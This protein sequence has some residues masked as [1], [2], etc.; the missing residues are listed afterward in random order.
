MCADTIT[1]HYH[2]VKPEISGSPTTWGVKLNADLD[3]IDAQL[4]TTTATANAASAAVSA[5][6]PNIVIGE[7]KLYAGG[8]L[9]LPANWLFC[10]GTVYNNTD[11]PLLAPVLNNAFGGV[12][13][14]SNAVP[15]LNLAF[16][17][18][19]DHVT[20]FIGQMGGEATHLL[21]AA[22]MPSHT[23]TP[24]VTDPGHVHGIPNVFQFGAVY[25]EGTGASNVFTYGGNTNSAPTGLTVANANTGGGVAHN[26][27]PPYVR[28]NFII[29]Y[30]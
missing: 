12:P 28:L 21:T 23:H 20:T 6:A 4:F 26:N 2:W 22:E 14:T 3:L 5:L 25:P 11:I 9:T 30:M 29:K 16:P 13:G 17:L 8:H 15:N 27:M 24:T 18:G 7:I 10:D 1:P 19:A